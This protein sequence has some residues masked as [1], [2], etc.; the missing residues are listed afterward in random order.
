MNNPLLVGAIDH[1][2]RPLGPFGGSGHSF[3]TA[4]L[5]MLVTDRQ[6]K[7]TFTNGNAHDESISFA[8]EHYEDFSIPSEVPVRY[9]SPTTWPI[10]WRPVLKRQIDAKEDRWAHLEKGYPYFKFINISFEFEDA[11]T[12]AA[13]HF[14]KLHINLEIGLPSDNNWSQIYHLESESNTLVRKGLTRFDQLTPG[15]INVLINSPDSEFSR[16][17]INAIRKTSRIY[18]PDIYKD[19]IFEIKFHDIYHNKE[20]V[21]NTL[22]TITGKGISAAANESY[23]DY[24]LAQLPINE[25]VISLGMRPN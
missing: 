8:F 23:D 19:R 16:R 2:G 3:I 10:V 1:R 7:M 5:M 24:L 18:P 13:Y 21:L 6:E 9:K 15:E 4:M 22:S 17:K 14:L 25:R 11:F 12:I 20:T